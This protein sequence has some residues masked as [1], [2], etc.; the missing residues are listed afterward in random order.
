M[1]GGE[2]KGKKKMFLFFLFNFLVIDFVVL[3]KSHT[4]EDKEGY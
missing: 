1:A 2:G 3:I 4:C